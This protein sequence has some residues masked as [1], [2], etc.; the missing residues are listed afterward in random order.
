M[1]PLCE[2]YYYVSPYAYCAGDPVNAIDPDGD[3]IFYMR[4]ILQG[5]NVINYE[6]YSYKMVN[7]EY[8]FYDNFDN[9]YK[10]GNTYLT[11]LQSSLSVLSQ[12]DNGLNII[13]ELSGVYNVEIKHGYNG[14]EGNKVGSTIS[15]DSQDENNGGIDI[16]G[17]SI[18]PSYIG[19]GHEL[20]HAVD[21]KN[22]T[23]L[24]GDWV[25]KST[26][27]NRIPNFEKY[28]CYVEN[29]LRREHNIPLRK[30]YSAIGN[31]G[32]EPTLILNKPY[33]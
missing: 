23:I 25:P 31:K 9:K 4:P 11:N 6:K 27:T 32:F 21:F 5:G 16:N 10:G 33:W 26:T 15:W 12:G 28:A 29:L 18:R 14:I 3:T 13:N 22:N 7:G 1:D 24:K 30:Y 19:L 2:K 20:A 17:S 8:A